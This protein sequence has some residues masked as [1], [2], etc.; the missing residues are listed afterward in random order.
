MRK[1][2]IL[3]MFLAAIL[4]SCQSKIVGE[5]SWLKKIDSEELSRIIINFGTKMKIDKHF[6]LE[7]SWAAYDDYTPAG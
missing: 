5:G 7:D 1:W 6:E 2:A 3:W 4:T